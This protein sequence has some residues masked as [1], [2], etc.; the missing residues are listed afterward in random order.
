[1]AASNQGSAIKFGMPACRRLLGVQVGSDLLGASS[2][3]PSE[4]VTFWFCRPVRSPRVLDLAGRSSEWASAAVR[5][6]PDD[7]N[8]N[9]EGRQDDLQVEACSR[10][11]WSRAVTPPITKTYRT[12]AY[13]ELIT[14]IYAWQTPIIPSRPTLTRPAILAPCRFTG[15]TN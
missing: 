7:S 3:A 11:L 14:R 6:C 8:S 1:V 2:K 12:S 9:Y 4:P 13:T 15:P 10:D 5:E